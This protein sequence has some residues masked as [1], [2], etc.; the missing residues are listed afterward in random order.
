MTFNG[1]FKNG[2][3]HGHGELIAEQKR[4]VGEWKNNRMEG[5]GM[6]QFGYTR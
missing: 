3:R 2:M 6:M 4:Y 1:E 5:Q